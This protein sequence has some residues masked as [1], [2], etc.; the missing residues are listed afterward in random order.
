MRRIMVCVRAFLL[1]LATLAAVPAA[2]ATFDGRFVVEKSG[3]I[4]QVYDLGGS[5]LGLMGLNR[6][7]GGDALPLSLLVSRVRGG[8]MLNAYVGDPAF[9]VGAPAAFTPLTEATA[10]VPTAPGRAYGALWIE[11]TGPSITF[12]HVQG[13]GTATLA[14]P[15]GDAFLPGNPLVATTPLPAGAWLLLGAL[16]MAAG[17]RRMRRRAA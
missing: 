12:A 9:F 3:G 10:L 5:Y 8:T 2:A 4:D 6:V 17:L 7:D 1:A 11:F 16:G 14:L 15:R 13:G